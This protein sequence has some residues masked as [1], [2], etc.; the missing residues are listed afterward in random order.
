MTSDIQV[1]TERSGAR[2]K[3]TTQNK[4]SATEPMVL[5]PR[6]NDADGKLKAES[7][8][9]LDPHGKARPNPDQE[10][11]LYVGNEV[12]GAWAGNKSRQQTKHVDRGMTGKNPPVVK[13]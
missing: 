4:N 10:R 7:Q 6:P 8:V 2:T 11:D 13:N 5:R 12:P 3:D 1:K 9:C